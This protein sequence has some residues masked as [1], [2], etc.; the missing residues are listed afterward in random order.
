[1]PVILTAHETEKG[2]LVDLAQRFELSRNSSKTITKQN[3][4][5]LEHKLLI[6]FPIYLKKIMV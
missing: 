3:H 1:M 5:K 6:F 4:Q 2:G